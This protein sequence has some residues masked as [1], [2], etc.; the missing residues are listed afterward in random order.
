LTTVAC[1]DMMVVD[2]LLKEAEPLEEKRS[3][4]MGEERSRVAF[5]EDEIVTDSSDVEERK[6]L[7]R[8]G[9]W[10]LVELTPAI[11]D[12]PIVSLLCLPTFNTTNIHV[13]ELMNT[14]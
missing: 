1:I 7:S 8:Y 5:S 11:E 6:L 14:L 9:V 13:D 2:R 10:L 12:V 4:E 3:V